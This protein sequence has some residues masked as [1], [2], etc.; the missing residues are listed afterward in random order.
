MIQMRSA[1][2]ILLAAAIFIN[3]FSCGSTDAAEPAEDTAVSDTAATTVEDEAP[4]LFT[5]TVSYPD[6]DGETL[7]V[8]TSN[9]IN[10]W[11]NNTI[12]NHAEEE[13]GEVVN[14][15]LFA[16]DRFAEERLNIKLE[17]TVD[18]TGN[19]GTQLSKLQ[20][21][22]TA[23]DNMADLVILDHAVICAGLAMKGLIYPLNYIDTINLS[24]DYWMPALNDKCRIGNSLYF[25]S[26]AISPR[27]YSS[28]YVTGINR[29]IAADIRRT[30]TRR[31]SGGEAGKLARGRSDERRDGRVGAGDNV[32]LGEPDDGVGENERGYS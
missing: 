15:S 4:A 6:L 18:Q 17:Y 3:L 19:T 24:S 23:G 32:S 10:G 16:R 8:Y 30:R 29:D 7:K 21:S 31:Q 2:A 27:Y 26:C 5:S 20:K 12:I 28:V 13:D 9:Y 25:A 11:T 22:I 1:A 14:D